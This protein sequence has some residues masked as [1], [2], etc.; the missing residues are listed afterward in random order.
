MTDETQ[1][2]NEQARKAPAPAADTEGEP[3]DLADRTEQAEG[4]VA[5][6]QAIPDLSDD[7]LRGR[8]ESLVEAQDPDQVIR[9]A[10]ALELQGRQQLD[11]DQEL[12]PVLN[13]ADR[14]CAT[15]YRIADAL[16]SESIPFVDVSERND[17][18]R[19]EHALE[20]I[21]D[22]LELLDLA[23]RQG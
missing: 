14:I 1:Q 13:A 12:V 15:L 7:E 10:I 16:G 22:A 3:A 9:N 11:V 19:I 2:E 6:L 23:K 8:F 21:V 17:I 18:E 5:V 20:N 4:L